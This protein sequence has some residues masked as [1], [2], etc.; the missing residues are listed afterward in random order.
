MHMGRKLAVLSDERELG[1][2]VMLFYLLLLSLLSF[3]MCPTDSMPNLGILLK[4]NSSFFLQSELYHILT[5][6]VSLSAKLVKIWAVRRRSRC[7]A[8]ERQSHELSPREEGWAIFESFPYVYCRWLQ[9]HPERAGKS[10]Y[11]C[12]RLARVPREPIYVKYLCSA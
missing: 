6:S 7:P 5:G 4:N 3:S 10:S 8:G 1:N 12:G 9:T 2:S 11:S